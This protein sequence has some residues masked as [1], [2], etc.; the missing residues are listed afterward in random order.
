MKNWVSHCRN[1]KLAV[2][3][4]ETQ[5]DDELKLYLSCFRNTHDVFLRFL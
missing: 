2:A 4:D 1:L 3:S 5:M